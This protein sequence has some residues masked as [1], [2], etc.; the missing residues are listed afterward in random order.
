MRKRYIQT[1]FFDLDGTLIDSGKDIIDAINWTLKKLGLE[2]RPYEDICRYIGYGRQPLISGVLGSYATAEL[3]ERASDIFAKRY[4][5]HMF[6]NTRLFPGVLD[7]L[8]YLKDK[9][10]MIATNKNRGLT[11]KT[12]AHFGIDKYFQRVAGGD[13]A[14]CRKPDSCQIV[15]L[16]AEVKTPRQE[17]IMIGD[18]DI[19]I[20]SGKMACIVTCGLTYG[21]GRRED[22]ERARPD[23]LLDNI[24]SLKEVVC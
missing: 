6:D 2:E 20:K 4:R 16:L 14:D 18:S 17:A 24:F 3:T 5:A 21:I 10:L 9:K 13:N 1:A 12:L 8:N 19:D 7:L 23:Y 22:L 11:L 15:S